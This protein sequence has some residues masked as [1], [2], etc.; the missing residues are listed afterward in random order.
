MQGMVCCNCVLCNLIGLQNFCSRYQMQ[1]RWFSW[2][3]ASL[4]EGKRG[5]YLPPL[6]FGLPPLGYVEN[7]ILHVNRLQRLL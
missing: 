1:Y 7:S 3:V 5:L 2:G 4:L 6:G